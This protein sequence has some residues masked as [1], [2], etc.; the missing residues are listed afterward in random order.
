[1]LGVVAARAVLSAGVGEGRAAS[2]RRRR[3][4]QPR[5]SAGPAV[6]GFAARI[7]SGARR[8]RGAAGAASWVRPPAAARITTASGSGEQS[9]ARRTMAS[10]TAVTP[11]RGRLPRLARK[12]GNGARRNSDG[13]IVVSGKVVQPGRASWQ[14]GSQ[15]SK[16]RPG[17][18]ERPGHATFKSA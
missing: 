14:V 4:W 18:T 13:H 7:G 16:Q 9:Q 5:A 1:M 2:L 8:W 6:V 12:A 11:I 3:P 10:Q 15:P 17:V